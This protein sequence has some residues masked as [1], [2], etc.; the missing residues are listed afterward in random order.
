MYMP[1]GGRVRKISKDTADLTVVNDLLYTRETE[2]ERLRVKHG[3]ETVF[4]A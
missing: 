1:V 2:H 3:A 4:M